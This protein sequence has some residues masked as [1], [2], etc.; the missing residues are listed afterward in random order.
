MDNQ[1]YI[2]KLE[3]LQEWNRQLTYMNDH[4]DQ[5]ISISY[6]KG[7]KGGLFLGVIFGM[8]SGVFTL[9]FL[10]WIN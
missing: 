8:L 6:A 5:I 3:R 7:L 10:R 9:L 1:E 4:I 2:S